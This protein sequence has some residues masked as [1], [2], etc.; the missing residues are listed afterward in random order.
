[1]TPDD[2]LRALYSYMTEKATREQ[3]RIKAFK[4]KY[5]FVP[6]KGDPTQGTITVDGKTYRVDM[7]IRNKKMNVKFPDGRCK[8]ISRRT[9]AI[10]SFPEPIIHLASDIFKGKK[11]EHARSDLQH[12]IGHINLHLKNANIS[13]NVSKKEL[14]EVIDREAK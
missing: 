11:A 4:K 1:M 7:D 6:D 3:Y 13:N 9:S 2:K 14:M 10:D 5:N 8:T 12:E